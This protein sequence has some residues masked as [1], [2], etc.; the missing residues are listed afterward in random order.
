M[1]RTAFVGLGRIASLLEDDPL[2]E[3]PASHAGAIAANPSCTIDGGY[4]I[5]AGASQRFAERWNAPVFDSAQTMLDEVRPDILVVATHPD[6]HEGYLRIAAERSVPVV[7]CEKPLAHSYRSARRMAQIERRSDTRVVVNHERRFSR[8]YRLAAEAVRLGTMGDLVSVSARLF[9][10]RTA[11]RDRVFLH[12]GTH[13]VDAIHFVTDDVIRL[14]GRYGSMQ[15]ARSSA[16]L[17]GVLRKRGIPVMIEH[18]SER[19]YLLFEVLLSFTSG[20]ILVGNGEFRWRRSVESPYYSNYRSLAPSSRSRP[21]PSGYFS[22]V[23]EE[24]VSL[25]DAP[26][27]RGMSTAT[28]AL[29]A[30]RVIA[31]SGGPFWRRRWN[32]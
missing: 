2:R 21:E 4:D 32:A 19:D 17:F 22:G 27:Q 30:M 10:G 15:S 26:N 14:T 7:I 28:D 24:A 1:A 20:E 31:G 18:G 5:D 9:F 13:L 8:D 23:V 11:R 12:D 3:K 25:L 6:S 16:F 29:E